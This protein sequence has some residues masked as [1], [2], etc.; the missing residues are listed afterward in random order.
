MGHPETFSTSRLPAPKGPY[1]QAVKAG[2]FL[3]V[4][5]LGAV[6][7][8]TGNLVEG[9]FEQQV[10]RTLENLQILVQDAGASM[11]RVVKTTVYLRDME[12]F[13]RMN[14]V[15]QQFFSANPPARTTIQA[16]GLPLN[17][18]IEIDAVVWTGGPEG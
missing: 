12:D 3:F 6:D 5:G 10:R 15:Y 2:C 4:S 14:S 9:D 18:S 16:G 13:A 17:M 1:S 7:P 8:Q 11:D